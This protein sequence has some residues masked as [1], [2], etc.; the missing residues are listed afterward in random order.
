[1]TAPAAPRNCGLGGWLL[2]GRILAAML[3]LMMPCTSIVQANWL[4]RL[5]GELGEAGGSVASKAARSFD[6]DL[7][8]AFRHLESLPE[9]PGTLALAVD[10]STAGHLKLVNRTGETFTAASEA[11]LARAVDVLSPGHAGPVAI[12]LTPDALFADR[13]MLGALPAQSEL[14]VVTKSGGARP[15]IMPGDAAAPRIT[16]SR[17]MTLEAPDASTLEEAMFQMGRRIAP[18]SVR[19]VALEP[20]GADALTAI[21]RFDPATKTALVDRVDPGSLPAAL[22]GVPGQTVVVSGKVADGQ[23]AFTASDGSSGMMPIAR[24]REAARAADVNLV[25]V[26][27]GSARQ[28]GGRNWLWQTV[29]VPGMTDAMKQATFGDFLSTLAGRETGLTATARLDGHGR[30]V[31]DVVPSASVPVPMSETVS[32]WLDMFSGEVIGRI[33]VAGVEADLRDEDRQQELDSRIIPG[34][35]AAVQWG[36][37]VLAALSLLGPVT[38]WRWWS[39]IWPA[40]RRGEYGNVAGFLAA[41]AVRI[42]VFLFIFLP[43]AGVPIALRFLALQVWSVISWPAR[44][45]TWVRARFSPRVT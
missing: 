32:E 30:V 44:F 28:P 34:V 43:L 37:V 10:A 39:G 31:V 11:E 17:Q 20:K 26:R 25:I 8:R 29:A 38:A 36:Y 5:A 16:F 41:R 6:A 13:A 14:Y 42:M 35:P 4:T 24:L 40:E 3:A 9:K 45:V 7:G 15:V 22:A 23:L 2:G 33:A 19:V 1:M 18:S 27:A 12:Y 21:P